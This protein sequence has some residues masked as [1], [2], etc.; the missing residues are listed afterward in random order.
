MI[1]FRPLPDLERPPPDLARDRGIHI[2]SVRLDPPEGRV[3]ELARLLSADEAERAA[4]FRFDRHRRRFTVGRGVLRQLLGRYLGVDPAQIAFRYGHR[5][6]PELAEGSPAGRLHFNLSH[7]EELALYALTWGRELGV[8]VEQ[9]RP[10]ED[11]EQIAERFFAAGERGVLR[12]VPDPLKARAFFNCWT[13]KEAYIKAVG[14]GLALPLDSFEVTLAPGEP[15]RML[16]M[17]GDAEKAGGWTL[18]EFEPEPGFV[19]ALAVEGLGWQVDCFR[20]GGA[21]RV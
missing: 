11:L 19:G 16:S 2:W 10:L 21:P 15:A 3:R 20:L 6:K 13:R 8:D 5:G 9:I 12:A 17:D 7:S 14:E 1:A 4:R 18:S